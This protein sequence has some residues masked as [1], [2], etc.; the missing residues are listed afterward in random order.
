VAGVAAE[1]LGEF[2]R[3][4]SRIL[5]QWRDE[6]VQRVR[7]TLTA[8]QVEQRRWHDV[9][10]LV[11]EWRAA[12]T[13]VLPLLRGEIPVPAT[14]PP[15][16][17]SIL[18][19]DLIVHETDIRAALGLPR[20]PASAA[21]SFAL[22]GYAFSLENRIRFL[23]LPGLVLAYDGK[24]RQLGEEPVGA[25]LAADRHDL[26]RVLAGRRTRAQI[27]ALTWTGDPGPFLDV[28]SEYGPATVVGVD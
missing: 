12:T 5:D 26:V 21:L 14:L 27:Q 20:A 22:A 16:V 10:A 7:D 13:E 1:D 6:E 15:V 23:G 4:S 3:L 11:S 2:G 18:V 25:S 8:R 28:L 17:G 19:N 24:E 9:P